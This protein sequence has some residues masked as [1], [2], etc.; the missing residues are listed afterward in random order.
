MAKRKKT[1]RKKQDETLVDLV[2]A[3]DQAQS[4]LDKNRNLIFGGLTALVVVIGGLF[5][6]NNFVKKPK[7]Q[8]AVSKVW[9]AEQQF[10]QDSFAMA[11]TNPGG[12]FDGLNDIMDNYGSS[13]TGNAAAFYAAVS[14]LQ[15][16]DYQQA[17][18]KLKGVDT[19]GEIMPI[20]KYGV[21]GDAY[22]ELGDLDKAMSNYQKA[23]ANGDNDALTPIYMMRV[24]ML[25]EKQGS[26]EDA[27]ATYQRIAT[28]YP[29]S[30]QGRDAEKFLIRLEDR[31]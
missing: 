1:N 28:D 31:G 24:G 16:G 9:R 30:N 15:L 17:I 8:E 25:H 19:E 22:S 27:I 12:S 3:R 29:L 14:Y 21:M 11:L 13:P 7:A 18:D 6:Y 10:F 23:V 5:F 2:E 4:F 20:L 26:V